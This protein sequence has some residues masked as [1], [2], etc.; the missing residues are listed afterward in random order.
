MKIIR[1]YLKLIIGIGV[2]I[3]AVLVFFRAQR[4]GD[5]EA[6]TLKNWQSASLERRQTAARI[7]TA[8]DENTDLLVACVDKMATLP[9]AGEMAVRDAISLCHTGIQLKSN[10]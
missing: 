7:T 5:L 2:L 10:L 3:L 1:K 8:S 6:G 4:A 9:D